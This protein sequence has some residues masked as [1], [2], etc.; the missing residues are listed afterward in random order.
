MQYPWHAFA[1]RIFSGVIILQWI[2]AIGIGLYQGQLL[3]SLLIATL[4]AAPPLL[5]IRTA[6]DQALTRHAIAIATQLL[7]ALHIHQAMGLIEI[8]FEIFTIL[9]ILSVYRD[10]KIIASAVAVV[11]IHHVAFFIAQLGGANL[12]V[13]EDGHVLWGIL[14]LHAF[15]AV[16]EGVALMFIA[17]NTHTEAVTAYAISSTIDQIVNNDKINVAN[18]SISNI[19]GE[20]IADFN[21]LLDSL[22]SLVSS[23][24]RDGK[25]ATEMSVSVSDSSAKIIVSARENQK[26]VESISTALDQV[27]LTNQ[28]VAENIEEVSGLSV[29]ASVETSNSKE[30]ID[31]N[32]D[33]AR[34]LKVEMDT[35]VQT[36]NELSRMCNDIDTFMSSIKAIAEQ[37]NLLALNAAIESARAGEHGRGFA[38]VADEVRQLATK[39][40]ENAAEI[41]AITENLVTSA[42]HA[43]TSIS[44]CAEKVESSVSS[45]ATTSETM[46]NIN[47]M[48]TR[49]T[50]N[51][52]SV[53]AA[54]IEQRSMSEQIT[55]SAE[56]LTTSSASQLN[57]LEQNVAELAAL[58]ESLMHLDNALAKFET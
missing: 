13:F 2:A 52:K 27:K 42:N 9:A 11:A 21:L 56:R 3:S 23:V 26:D 32:L 10:W 5:M 41:S 15:F 25:H 37:T 48:I 53:E 24:K 40:G 58:K 17:K 55:D 7:T 29:D 46:A 28:S 6:P 36:I 44:G 45:T 20:T 18:K 30:Q 8:H 16:A 57:Q 39:T 38:V 31:R 51:M 22:C 54:T 33:E 1:H 49:L 12:F 50:D 35:A 19:E 43:M 14:F 4:F 34:H 47:Q